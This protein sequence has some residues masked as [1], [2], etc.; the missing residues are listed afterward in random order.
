MKT[1]GIK[2]DDIVLVDRRG[3]QFEAIVAGREPDGRRLSIRP[4]RPAVSYMSAGAREI[5]GHWRARPH[6]STGRVST[7][8]I[9]A[10]DVVKFRVGDCTA[11]GTVSSKDQGTLNVT[12]LKRSGA[13]VPVAAGDIVRHYARHGRARGRAV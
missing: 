1:A 3:R 2:N 12:P 4:L 8:P 5:I 13:P 11:F 7:R 10:G 9:R 6:V